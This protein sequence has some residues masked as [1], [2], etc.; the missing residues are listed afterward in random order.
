MLFLSRSLQ[1]TAGL[2]D[3]QPSVNHYGVYYKGQ[4]ER[5]SITGILQWVS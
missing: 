4:L 3:S 2:T 5:K 1:V